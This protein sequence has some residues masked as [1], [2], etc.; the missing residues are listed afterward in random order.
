MAHRFGRRSATPAR[1]L[2]HRLILHQLSKPTIIV[3]RDATSHAVRHLHPLSL[4]GDIQADIDD[5]PHK[6]FP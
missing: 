4:I 1:S 6:R 2:I 5:D 3:M